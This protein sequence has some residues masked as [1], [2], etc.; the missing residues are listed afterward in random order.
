M[1]YEDLMAWGVG[2]V[3]VLLRL[4]GALPMIERQPENGGT[5]FSGCLFGGQPE[6]LF[7]LG[8]MMYGDLMAL[9]L[10]L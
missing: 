7:T 2:G 1:A 4:V 5:D 6:K 10:C 8:V 3:A 9:V